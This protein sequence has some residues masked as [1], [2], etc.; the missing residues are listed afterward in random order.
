M[1]HIVVKEDSFF[2]FKNP[3]EGC[4]TETT[5][6]CIQITRLE[7][8][9]KYSWERGFWDKVK[10]KRCS[11]HY[12]LVTFTDG[13]GSGTCEVDICSDW[14]PV[15]D[16]LQLE[17]QPGEMFEFTDAHGKPFGENNW[18]NDE[19]GHEI[20]ISRDNIYTCTSHLR[21]PEWIGDVFDHSLYFTDGEQTFHTRTSRHGR[22][23]EVKFDYDTGMRVKGNDWKVR[24]ITDRWQ[25]AVSRIPQPGDV[26]E[27]VD[28][29]GQPCNGSHNFDDDLSETW[30]SVGL[31]RFVC[32]AHLETSDYRALE[33]E[34]QPCGRCDHSVFFTDGNSLFEVRVD[35]TSTGYCASRS[36]G[37]YSLRALEVK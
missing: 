8:D 11:K 28:F 16:T 23:S 6:Y 24:R 33:R 22:Y 5:Y 37:V 21:N 20:E 9:Y 2:R 1:A 19:Y 36:S 12:A 15:D 13:H 7:D 3:P 27:F 17:L 25:R 26:F 10:C 4:D 29:D 34:V 32:L 18:V 31:N 14:Y 35:V 30:V